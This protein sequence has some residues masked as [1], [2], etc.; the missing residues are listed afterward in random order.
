MYKVSLTRWGRC[1][2]RRSAFKFEVPDNYF[3]FEQI[4][5]TEFTP[6][7]GHIDFVKP[8]D[9][10]EAVEDAAASNNNAQNQLMPATRD[11]TK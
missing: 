6:R 3:V 11:I 10:Q 9:K 8:G 5:P 2:L 4:G 7:N 1:G